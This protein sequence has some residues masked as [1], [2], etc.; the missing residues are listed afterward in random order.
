[1]EKVRQAVEEV[2][3]NVKPNEEISLMRLSELT[4]EVRMKVEGSTEEERRY[5]NPLPTH[6]TIHF[7]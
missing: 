7:N 3:K 4:L 6:L 2:F 5:A 1:M